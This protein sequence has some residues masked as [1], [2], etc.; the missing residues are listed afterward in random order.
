MK[1]AMFSD[2]YSPYT[3]GVVR[4]VETFTNELTRLGH[5][6]FIFAPNYPNCEK[7]SGVYRFF[8]IPSPTNKDFALAFPFSLS[9]WSKVKK[10]QPDIIHVHSPF[11][12]GRLG[13]KWARRLGI[14][15]VFTYHTLYDKYVHYIPINQQIVKELTIKMTMDF[16]NHCDQVITPTKIIANHL[17]E[18]GVEVPVTAV[19]TGII[20]EE[21]Q[22]ADKSWLRSRYNIPL[23]KKI[24]LFVGRLGKEKNISF[25]LDCYLEIFK[26]YQDTVLV[27]VGSGPDEESLKE[28]V[29]EYR[30]QNN[31]IFT[32]TLSKTDTINAY[33]GADI[34][35]FASVTETQGLVMAEA[36][37]AGLPVIAVDAFGAKEMVV[38]GEDG[39][40]CPLDINI[41]SKTV[42]K[43]ITDTNLCRQ[44][45]QKAVQNAKKLSAQ[46]CTLKLL[47]VYENV[48][49]NNHLQ[50][51]RLHG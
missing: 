10:L 37:T 46:S 38:D 11:L 9:L 35:V 29:K 39:Y 27:L 41:F 26:Q 12:L 47:D 7:E 42:L 1:I 45:G 25:L 31:V 8:S 20:T 21:F 33:S 5:Q 51:R 19:P 15:L 23:D 18:N 3:S 4:S 28:K 44:M 32:G 2:S 24:L 36:K 13:A 30:L 49:K 43:L 48:I 16:C 17:I 50:N 34:F 22:N 6:V 14:P 40:L